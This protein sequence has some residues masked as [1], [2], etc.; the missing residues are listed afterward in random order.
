MLAFEVSRQLRQR[1]K[2]PRGIILIDS[3]TPIGHEPLPK[4]VISH[5]VS[6]TASQRGSEAAAEARSCI[7]AQFRRHA[8][9]LQKYDP[10][11]EEGDVQ[12]VS[13]SCVR[14]MDTQELCGVSYP[15][16]AEDGFRRES[17]RSWERL[18]KQ[19]IAVLEVDCNHFEVFEPS[20]VSL[21]IGNHWG[22][23]RR[24]TDDG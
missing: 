21:V 15:W 3:P 19:S 11:P 16:L 10:L 5:V 20:Y 6:K 24:G 7:E 1:G 18:L 22:M 14:T 17:L 4:E 12:C 8:G 13:I 23:T 2:P 9:L